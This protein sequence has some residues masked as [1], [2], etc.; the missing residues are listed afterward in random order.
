MGL[1]KA[2]AAI[3]ALLGEVLSFIRELRRKKKLDEADERH[4]QNAADIERA[5]SPVGMRVDGTDSKPCSKTFEPTGL[6]GGEGS[7]T[8]M[9]EGRP[10]DGERSAKGG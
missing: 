7:G 2:I 4:S 6:S 5:F 9:G 3:A 10:A 1:L 8:G